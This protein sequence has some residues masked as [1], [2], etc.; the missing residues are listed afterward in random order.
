MQLDST[1]FLVDDDEAVRE[2]IVML[3]ETEGFKVAAFTSA[4]AFL[5]Y[6]QPEWPGCLVLDVSMP[7]ITGLQLQQILMERQISIPLIFI[8]GHG[9]VPMSVKAIRAGAMDFIEKPF[10][11]DVL[12]S[13][14]REAIALDRQ[15]REAEALKL[16]NA[17]HNYAESMVETIREPLLVLD[18][19]LHVLSANRSFYQ[20]FQIS[21]SSTH[22]SDL[23]RRIESILWEIPRL[24]TNLK[25]VMEN[26][27]E[28]HELELEY[29][30]GASRRIIRCN[31]CEL[32]QP[33]YQPR[34]F[35]LTMEDITRRKQ[36][37]QQAEA[38]LQSAPDAIVVVNEN[39]EITFVNQRT[40]NLFGYDK[41]ELIGRNLE[42]LLPGRFKRRHPQRHH[43]NN[44][45]N[46]Y[47]TRSNST[48]KDLF[49]R[50]KDGARIPVD[51]SFSPFESMDGALVVGAIRDITERK[52]I[53]EELRRHREHLEDLVA[54]R[55][56]DLQAMNK[57]L[58]SYSYS[59]AHDLRTPLR[60][61]TSFS[62]ILREDAKDKLTQSDMEHLHRVIAAGKKMSELIDDIL[63]LS[64]ITRKE[65]HSTTVNLT[66]IA[67][68][69]IDRLKQAHPDRV[70]DCRVQDKLIVNGDERL[71]E[72]VLQNL[73]E[74]AWKFTQDTS[75]S[76]IQIGALGN[77]A[78]PTYFVK[79]NGIGFDLQY[80][81]KLFQPF[82]RLHTAEKYE[83][84]GIGLATVKRIIQRHGGQIWAHSEKGQGATF[85][86]SLPL[87]TH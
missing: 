67:T 42:V 43:S 49:G 40:V 7:G 78:E 5:N 59:I 45:N 71:L 47:K 87:K 30:T 57:E 51:V 64:R 70:V 31:A 50:H 84:T 48:E 19:E 14:I 41:D 75:P 6:Y 20:T 73:L 11:E 62:Q 65:I 82:H 54:Q 74:N 3:L 18:E 33:S 39:G 29:D 55:T 52:Q 27:T 24:K 85:Y 36:S 15:L 77:N 4:E 44:N 86:F 66:H 53:E 28:L 80:L 76:I 34:R 58:E 38:L 83:G 17:I 35:L 63:E 21:L 61:I 60:A 79:D 37:E 16:I 22:A 69:I 25:S 10:N 68:D 32:W 12:I 46:A 9:D 23:S 2:S 72:R 13:R 81:E 56:T 8:T 26:K 1:V